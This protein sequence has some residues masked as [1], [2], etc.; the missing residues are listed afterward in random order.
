MVELFPAVWNA[1]EAITSPDVDVRLDGLTALEET[2][3]AYYSPLVAYL[4]A[5]RLVDPD[6]KM[7]ARVIGLL[8]DVI[9]TVDVDPI[10]LQD[11]RQHV[12]AYS[13]KCA[14]GKFFTSYRRWHTTVQSTNR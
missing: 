10:I 9:Q 3:A 12:A 5:S 11:V 2:N 6:L 8:G 13:T 4:V 7:R 14:P 1:A